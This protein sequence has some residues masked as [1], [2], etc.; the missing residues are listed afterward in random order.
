MPVVVDKMPSRPWQYLHMAAFLSDF[1]RC[2]FLSHILILFVI[3]FMV[4]ESD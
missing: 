3:L 4:Y 2:F 1:I